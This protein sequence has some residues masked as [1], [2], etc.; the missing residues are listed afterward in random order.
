MRRAACVW[1]HTSASDQPISVNGHLP[2]PT[3][4]IEQDLKGGRKAGYGRRNAMEMELGPE[5]HEYP[6]PWAGLPG[7]FSHF[8]LPTLHLVSLEM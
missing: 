7:F 6:S 4:G 5:L 1:K 3:S 2:I 8:Q